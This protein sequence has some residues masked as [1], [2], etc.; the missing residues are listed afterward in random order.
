ME[1]NRKSVEKNDLFEKIPMKGVKH[2]IVVASGKGGVGKSTVA[3]N[4]AVALAREGLSIALVDADIFGPSIPKMF[5]IEDE[6]PEIAA[7]GDKEVLFPIV[8]YGVKIMSIGFFIDRNQ[9]LIWRGPMAGKAVTQL[10]S[11]TDWGEIDYMIIDFPPGTSDIQLTT[12]QKLNLSGALIVTTPQEISLNDARKAA[13]MFTTPDLE[14]P[15]LGVIENM[16]W[17]SPAKHPDEIYYIF[18]KGG[19]LQLAK[20]FDTILLGQ[21]PLVMEVGEAAEKGLSVFSQNNKPVVRAFEEMASNIISRTEK[22]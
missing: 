12:V 1:Q 16:S 6:K 3:A 10:F 15:I 17:F 18:G 4:L 7:F 21:I 19:G 11:D 13:S 9:S 22:A 20:E 5:G 14:V 2:I 8:K